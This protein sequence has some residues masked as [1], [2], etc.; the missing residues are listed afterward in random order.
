[1]ANWKWDAIEGKLSIQEIYTAVTNVIQVPYGG[2]NN[3]AANASGEPILEAIQIAG[4]S[5]MPVSLN[6]GLKHLTAS[7][8]TNV[9]PVADK[10]AY[11]AMMQIVEWIKLLS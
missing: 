4:T 10:Y 1:M 7:F 6:V 5:N 11:D 3:A 2:I 8:E 9:L